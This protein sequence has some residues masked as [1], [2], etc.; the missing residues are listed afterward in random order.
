MRSASYA[1]TVYQPRRDSDPYGAS[2]FD[3]K[4]ASGGLDQTVLE[5]THRNISYRIAKGRQPWTMF[6]T[7]K[8]LLARSLMCLLERRPT[9]S[10][11]S[12]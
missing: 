12:S 10:K 4:K 11:A 3:G 7:L 1:S 2:R 5:H 6:Q 9:E 8:F